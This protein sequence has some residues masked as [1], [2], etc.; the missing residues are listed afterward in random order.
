MTNLKGQKAIF[1]ASQDAL[2]V[3]GV[4]HCVKMCKYG[5]FVANM[6]KYG[7]FIAKIC[8][9]AVLFAKICK[10]AHINSL[11]LWSSIAPQ[12]MLST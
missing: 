10:Y 2:E 5:I 6:R 12:I 4:T 11:L 8:K 3:M 7:I 9:Y 1:L